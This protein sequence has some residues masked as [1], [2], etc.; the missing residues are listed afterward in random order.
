[1]GTSFATRNQTTQ[2]ENRSEG[3]SHFTFTD[4]EK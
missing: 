2:F 1:M 3:A 4:F